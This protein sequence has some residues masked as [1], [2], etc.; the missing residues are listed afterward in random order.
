M[1]VCDIY[2][3]CVGTPLKYLA[4]RISEDCPW[5]PVTLHILN[6]FIYRKPLCWY[7][8]SSV[9]VFVFHPQFRGLLLFHWIHFPRVWDTSLCAVSFASPSC[10]LSVKA[11]EMAEEAIFL[12]PIISQL[13]LWLELLSD[14]ME[15]SCRSCTKGGLYMQR[16]QGAE[17]HIATRCRRLS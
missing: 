16:K 12:W 13:V 7:W 3:V 14:V 17:R 1:I 15:E 9:G 4:Q 2:K 10:G 11:R 6:P 5:P 8:F